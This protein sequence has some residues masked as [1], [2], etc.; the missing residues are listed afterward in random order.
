MD[1]VALTHSDLYVGF[2]KTEKSL[3]KFDEIKKHLEKMQ[4]EQLEKSKRFRGVP[5]DHHVHMQWLFEYIRDRLTKLTLDAPIVITPSRY[6][7]L[8]TKPGELHPTI[9][10]IDKYNLYAS[11]DYTILFGLDETSEVTLFYDD[12]RHLNKRWHIPLEK[13]KFIMFN[14]SIKYQISPNKSKENRFI[15]KIKSQIV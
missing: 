14:S 2:F 4:G 12:H 10:D 11:P 9:Y 3:I 6:E 8:L 5:L 13:D 7:L 1:K 15:I